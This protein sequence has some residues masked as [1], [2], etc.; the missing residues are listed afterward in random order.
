MANTY[1]ELI[2]EIRD[3]LEKRT[4][5]AMEILD[6]AKVNYINESIS[7]KVPEQKKERVARFLSFNIGLNGT[8]EVDYA[9]ER[10][11]YFPDKMEEDIIR[12]TIASANGIGFG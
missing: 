4:R 8:Y 5:E 10:A 11:V 9:N 3:R 6:D 1:Y 2:Y 7:G 12:A